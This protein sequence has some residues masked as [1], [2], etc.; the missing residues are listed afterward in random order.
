MPDLIF[1]KDW[2]IVCEGGSDKAF[3]AEL[4]RV[5]GLPQFNI[6]YPLRRGDDSGGWTKFNRF[7]SGIQLLE[8]FK[9]AT[10]AILVVAD[11][12]DDPPTRFGEIREKVQSAGFNAPTEPLKVARTAGLPAIVI[13]MVPMGGA[14][15]NLETLLLPPA[16]SR[17]TGLAA[18]LD[19]FLSGSPANDWEDR[20]KAKAKMRCVLASTC[21]QDPNTSLKYLWGRADEFHI[22]VTHPSLD[23]IANVLRDFGGIIS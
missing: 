6:Y 13:L 7:L 11:N 16:L 3:L 20:R 17:W 9:K 8:D 10:K 1:D 4:I 19:A 18:P 21:K 12:D 5:R 23:P 2:L 15:G 14:P 22:P